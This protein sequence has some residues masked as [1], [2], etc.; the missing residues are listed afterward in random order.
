MTRMANGAK[1]LSRTASMRAQGVRHGLKDRILE[2][3]LD[4]AHQETDR[5]EH[6]NSMLRDQIEESHQEHE[7]IIDLI[8]ERLTRSKGKGGR[9]FLMLLLAIGGFVWMR[10]RDPEMVDRMLGRAKEMT[11]GLRS[12]MGSQLA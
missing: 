3:R 9:V 1:V 4:R 5:L 2:R 12:E 7:R 10:M 6:E 8:D 11:N